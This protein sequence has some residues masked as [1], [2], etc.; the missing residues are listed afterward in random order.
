[1]ISTSTFVFHQEMYVCTGR[2]QVG[3][4]SYGPPFSPYRSHYCNVTKLGSVAAQLVGVLCP[5]LVVSTV[6]TY[7]PPYHTTLLRVRS[8]GF[9]SPTERDQA[10][11]CVGYVTHVCLLGVWYCSMVH[12]YVGIVQVVLVL[13]VIPLSV[14]SGH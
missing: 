12:T 8:I 6:L 13:R 1:M 7:S 9:E 11:I 2:V 5:L 3:Y 4:R 14:V 10:G